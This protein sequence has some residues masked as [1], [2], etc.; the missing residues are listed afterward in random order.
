MAS[1]CSR[2]KTKGCPALAS[3]PPPRGTATIRVPGILRVHRPGRGTG[4]RSGRVQC[5]C[6]RWQSGGQILKQATMPFARKCQRNLHRSS[7][8][9]KA[10]SPGT[11]RNT[12]SGTHRA[13]AVKSR[14]CRHRTCSST[15][16]GWAQQAEKVMDCT[17]SPSTPWKWDGCQ[18]RA[19]QAAESG[20][21]QH[22]R[23][24]CSRR[25]A[26]EADA[27]HKIA[28][29]GVQASRNGLN[30]VQRFAW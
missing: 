25:D 4:N 6:V 29:S 5:A 21:P 13:T 11:G 23:R 28:P 22:P 1:G 19:A 26:E 24:R 17:T 20:G 9:R 30:R 15:T 8:K 10:F 7:Q 14:I 2:S 16:G 27:L 3:S 12:W 18:L